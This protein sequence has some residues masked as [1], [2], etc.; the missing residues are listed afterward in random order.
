MLEQNPELTPEIKALI[1]KA[2][3]GD[4]DAH[5]KLGVIYEQGKGVAQSDEKAVKYYQLAAEQ[6]DACG[7]CNLGLMYEQ[8]K[9]VAQSD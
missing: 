2:Q 6:G 3:S 8:G 9:G 1:E 5:C 7:Q 4:A